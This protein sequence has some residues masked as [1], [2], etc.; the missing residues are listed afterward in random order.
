MLNDVKN[1]KKFPVL[2]N[3]HSK[4]TEKTITYI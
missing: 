2:C 1:V 4:K 3:K